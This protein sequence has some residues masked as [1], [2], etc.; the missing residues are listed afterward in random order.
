MHLL[1]RVP[2]LHILPA[3]DVFQAGNVVAH[4]TRGL[5][6]IE[7]DGLAL[8][9]NT[10]TVARVVHFLERAVPAGNDALLEHSRVLVLIRLRVGRIVSKVGFL[11]GGNQGNELAL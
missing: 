9:E 8:K 1:R 5:R 10:R 6:V 2:R 7:A 11:H 4:R 3:T